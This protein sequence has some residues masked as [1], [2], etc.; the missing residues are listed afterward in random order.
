VG[1]LR[2]AR[3]YDRSETRDRLQVRA[4]GDGVPIEPKQKPYNGVT[5]TDRNVCRCFTDHRTGNRVRGRRGKGEQVTEMPTGEVREMRTAETVLSINKS[6]ESLVRR[7]RSCGVRRGAERKVPTQV[8]N[9]LA[10]YSTSRSR[11]LRSSLR[12]GEPITWRRGTGG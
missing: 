10:A 4:Y 1:Y 6:L 7:K 8:G 11:S 9:S 2:H 5:Q 12:L 3:T